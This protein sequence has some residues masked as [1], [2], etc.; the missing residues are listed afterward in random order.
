M[1]MTFLTFMIQIY[2]YSL[3]PNTQ[4]NILINEYNNNVHV[5]ENC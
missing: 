4:L 2:F 3:R 5:D 1:T